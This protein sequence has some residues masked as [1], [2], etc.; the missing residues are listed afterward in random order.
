[1]VQ[2]SLFYH[3]FNQHLLN[4]YYI[5]WSA[6]DAESTELN[7]QYKRSGLLELTVGQR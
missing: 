3:K 5:P 6:G 2:C 4:I 1:M 7:A